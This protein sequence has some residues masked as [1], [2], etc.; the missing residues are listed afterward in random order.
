MRAG[1]AVF[2][3]VLAR[4]RRRPA[5]WLLTVLG[6][7]LATAF[8]GAVYAQGTIAGD[9]AARSV[10][11]RLSD[12][13]RVVTVTSQDVVT[14]AIERRARDLLRGLGLQAPTEVVLMSPVRLSGVVVRL[15]AIAPLRPWITAAVP[16][17]LQHC[18]TAGCPT[19]LANGQVG[20][21]VLTADGL[22]FPVLSREPLRSAA[23]LGFVPGQP[24]GQPRVLLTADPVGLDGLTALDSLYRT[25]SWLS[26]L[27]AT[28]L[29][30]WQLAAIERRL[31]ESQ[32]ALSQA[33][34]L[35][36][37]GPFAALDAAR[38]DAGA[39]PRRLLLAAGGSISALVLFL[40]L[41]V[42]A[43]RRDVEAEL[44][45]LDIA[46]AR[47]VDRLLFVVLEGGMVCATALAL[48]AVLGVGVAALEAA[49]S[50][51]PIGAILTHSLL[52]GSAALALAGAWVCAT[53]MLALLLLVRGARVADALA[54]AALAALAVVL[55]TGSNGHDALT[56]LLAPMACLA[57][58]VLV[59]RGASQLMRAGER[60]AR[61]G[62]VMTRLAFVGL[63]RSPTG[64]SLA[65]SFIAV[66]TGLGAFAL[67][68]R[69][70]LVRSTADQAAAQVPLDATVT[71]GAD[72]TPP[73]SLA[74]LQ[75]WRTLAGGPVFPVRRT[76][77]SFVSGDSSLTVP[78][79]G[80]PAAALARLHGWRSGDGSAPL[81]ALARRITPTGPGRSPGPRLTPGS[82]RLELRASSRGIAVTITADLR[83]PDGSV[84]QLPLGQS[85]PRG[86]L[87]GAR[88]PRAATTGPWELEALQATEPAGLEATNGHQNAENPAAA[89]QF[90]TLLRL[91]PLQLASR[92][93][94]VTRVPINRWTT[95]GAISS[96]R[97]VRGGLLVLF[98]ATGETG[99]IRP[100]QPS[101]THP[102]PVLVD[103][104]TALLAGPGHRLGLTVDGLAIQTRVVGVL[105][106]FPTIPAGTSGFV[107]ADEAALA[108]ALDAQSPG[109][110]RPDELWVSSTDP[111]RLRAGL[112]T[113]P[114]HQLEVSFR[115]DI[116]HALRNAPVAR[117][118]LG[119]LIAA[120]ALAAALAVLGLL[121]ALLGSAR[122]PRIEADLVAQGV[123]PRAMRTELRVRL[124]SAGAI[125]V[126]AGTVIGVVLTRLAVATVRAAGTVAVP[127]PPVV[128][129]APW[130][131]LGLWS[132]AVLATLSLGAWA[133]TRIVVG[134]TV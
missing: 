1:A 118:V 19:V 39:A 84:I 32:A 40:V 62:P 128:V 83:R 56:V 96:P 79:L 82:E 102:L 115:T 131:G 88:L 111:N 9:R 116:E 124:L 78:A 14:P 65:I 113:G 41:S 33:S 44:G 72:F 97:V 60:I 13:Q 106:R 53:A 105:D 75:R 25:H 10:L 57:A 74:P 91:G 133:A 101:D 7:A 93:G 23:P 31:L 42:G 45:R 70:T 5:R 125:G 35:T 114:L 100:Q 11:T 54:L 107:V 80:V 120:S 43:V 49:G 104:H 121:V 48:G 4:V 77:A 94:A 69:A 17:A 103:P 89:T 3:L 21:H 16:P 30:S 123:G 55:T 27:P 130:L 81:S 38:S 61:R 12:S 73:L 86:T 110:G 2:R 63:A 59:Y 58:G 52:T 18:T 122:D 68:Y 112:A 119:T 109:Q 85:G 22:S 64:A 90:A 108:S 20:H 34:G 36:L 71:A 134:R 127:R 99:L 47:T 46:G 67:A 98:S 92:T 50:G 6:I 28:G 76:D 117:G 37:S 87:L 15:A 126:C 24:A 129:V 29:H 95:V 66:S 51:E 8:A 26:L 132:L